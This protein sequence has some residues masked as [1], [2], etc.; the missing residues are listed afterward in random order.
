MSFTESHRVHTRTRSPGALWSG[1]QWGAGTHAARAQRQCGDGTTRASCPV[2]CMRVRFDPDHSHSTLEL[3]TNLH[4]H[5][6][7][8][9][10]RARFGIAS[11]RLPRHREMSALL[12]PQTQPSLSGPSPSGRVCDSYAPH[13]YIEG[14]CKDCHQ[15]EALHHG[16]MDVPAGSTAASSQVQPVL[17]PMEQGQN[18]TFGQGEPP[19][20][21]SSPTAQSPTKPTGR[22]QQQQHTTRML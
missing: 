3:S 12:S 14:K 18:Q 22:T 5:L 20:L 15:A 21:M 6:A 11:S 16:G 19:Q 9:L 1:E 17:T 8:P 13:A 4:L 10:H 7:S 2:P